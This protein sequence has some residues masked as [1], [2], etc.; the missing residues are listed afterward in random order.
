MQNRKAI[1]IHGMWSTGSTLSTLRKRLETRGYRVYSPNLPC[2]EDGIQELE[3]EVAGMSILDYT[4]YLKDYI[5][6]LKLEESPILIG[7]SMGGLL[8]QKLSAVI[9]VSA[10]V[11]LCPAQPWGINII[12][13][14]GVWATFN[15]YA[16]WRFWGKS[17]RPSL[18]RAK[19]GIFNIL[20]GENQIKLYNRL[21]P[22][23]GRVYFEI[24]FWFLDRQKAT[25]VPTK[26]IATPILAIAGEKDRLIPPG[27]VKKIAAH[28]PTAD[29]KCYPDHTH[30]LIDEP[31]SEVIV[32]D[33]D[34]WL[35]GK[36][37]NK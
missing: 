6:S 32:D 22:E 16:K 23:S 18:Y 36:L 3:S 27:I 24:V 20:D 19:Y 9:D 10:L 7:H 21:I 2:H 34:T 8:A 1:L 14:T 15:A 33:I 35:K 12:T 13:P 30:W 11:L 17:H 26:E 37:D 4:D 5:I 25:R 31:G 29:Y 28:Y